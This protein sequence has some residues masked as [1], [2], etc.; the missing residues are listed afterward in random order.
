MEQQPLPNLPNEQ[1][2]QL[3]DFHLEDYIQIAEEVFNRG[4]E[5]A[6]LLPPPLPPP[7]QLHHQQENRDTNDG[8]CYIEKFPKEYLAG[9]TWGNCKPM[10]ECLDEEQKRRVVLIGVLLKMR[11]NGNLPSG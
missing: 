11:M 5:E 8:H 3:E 2:L 7:P 1:E 10:Y 6:H 4:L 9:T